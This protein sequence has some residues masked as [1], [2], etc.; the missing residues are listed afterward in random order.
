MFT[1]K[2]LTKAVSI[3]NIMCFP[4]V[5]ADD[6]SSTAPQRVG[7]ILV[8][9]SLLQGLIKMA[10]NSPHSKDRPSAYLEFQLGSFKV[11]SIDQV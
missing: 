3:M 2:L 7:I 4:A 1:D 6:C 8:F 10:L 11:L 9:S 5:H